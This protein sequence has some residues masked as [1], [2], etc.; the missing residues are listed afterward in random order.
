MY[1]CDNWYMWIHICTYRCMWVLMYVS[2]W[3]WMYVSMHCL[4]SHGQW[5]PILGLAYVHITSGRRTGQD[6]PRMS[7]G[8]GDSSPWRQQERREGDSRTSVR[9]DRPT[10]TSY[11]QTQT[12]SSYRE[13]AHRLLQ[14]LHLS[15]N[16]AGFSEG[17]GDGTLSLLH[18]W[19]VFVGGGCAPRYVSL[20]RVRHRVDGVL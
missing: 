4:N 10:H 2:I 18:N 11:V 20:V 14:W 6:T 7:E 3:I 1:V 16:S 5:L 12:T 19:W 15:T 9:K 17:D 8:G 13:L